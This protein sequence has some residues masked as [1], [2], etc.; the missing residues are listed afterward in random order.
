M[1]AKTSPHYR[2]LRS[3][4]E[5][6]TAANRLA[7]HRCRALSLFVVAL[8]LTALAVSAAANVPVSSPILISQENSTRAIAVDSLSFTAEPFA[9]TSPYA[10]GSDRR[11]RVTLFALN[12]SL[13]PGEDLSL[14]TADAEDGSH[15]HYNLTVEYVGPVPHQEWLSA[16]V[17]R[18]NDSLG[19]VGDV[20]VRVSLRG[21]SSNR[22]RV[23]I[24]H[25]GGGPPDDQGAT[26]TPIKPFFI[27]GQVREDN[28]SAV[29][30]VEVTLNDRTDGT[31]SIATTA[32]DGSYFFSVQ[33]GHSIAVTLSSNVFNFGAQS[34]D[35]L[36]G[37]RVL[38]FS[39]ARRAY[40]IGGHLIGVVNSG[41]VV[42]LSGFR[43]ATTT[44]NNNGDFE[45][46]NLTAGR[47]YTISIPTTPYYTFT[48]QDFF[49]LTGNRVADFPGTLRYY[50]VSG[51]VWLTHDPARHLLIPVSGTRTTTVTTND[52]GEFSISLPAGGNYDFTPSVSYFTFSPPSQGVTNLTSD[53]GGEVFYGVRQ[54]FTI[55]GKL[56]DQESNALPGLTVNL[57]GEEQRT[58]VTDSAGN[59]EFRNLLAGYSYTITPPSTASY[60][61]AA[62]NVNDLPAN[63]TVDFVGLRRLQLSGRVTD[64]SGNALIGITIT[65]AGTESGSTK[66]AADGSYSL[67]ATATGNYTVTPSIPQDYYTFAPASVQF[68][69]LAAASR[70]DF[71][72]APTA[73]PNP[74]QVLEFDGTPKTVDYG[75]FW[76][77]NV[78]LGHFFWEFWAMPGG[79][80]GATYLLSDGY[81]GAHA[82]LFGVGSFNSSEVNRYELLGN[83]FDG[84][85]FDHYFGG[86]VGPAVGEWAHF[87]VGWDGQNIITYYN[88]VPVGKTPFAGPRRTP[89][90]GGGGGRLLIGGSDHSN[91]DGR[92]AEVRGYEDFNPREGAPGSSEASFSPGTVFARGGNLL[93]YF[94]RSSPR[95]IA[96]LSVGYRGSSHAGLLRGTSTG[97]IE[98][99]ESCP[100]PRF[101]TDPSAP[102]FTTGTP[103][104][105]VNVPP[106]ASP[107]G[108]ALI[109]D[110]FSRAN[111]TYTF[112]GLG[113]LGFTESGAAGTKVW[114]SNQAPANPQPFGILNARAVLLA[115]AT[116]VAW[117]PTGSASG[118][119]DVRVSR[120]TGRWGSGIHTGLSFRVVDASNF[121]FAYTADSGSAATS[122]L[123]HVGYYLNGQRVDLTAGVSI[124]SSWTTLR[125]VTIN[126]GALNVYVDDALVYAANSPLLATANGAGLYSDSPGM[127]LVNRWDNFTVL[128]SP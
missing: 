119:L 115:N 7:D 97:L 36:S 64:T 51:R 71:T 6:P 74:S 26:P 86:D 33:P 43:T 34:I 104:A 80:A 13:Q 117:V 93:S 116:A 59:Y 39:G 106:A 9:L 8:S 94:F 105:P 99:C 15:Q 124:P 128:N 69:N 54:L 19:D 32:A 107:P 121:F 42:N 76:P 126:S 92:I 40:A 46:A 89:G 49:N 22:V 88:G 83:I 96:D 67:T 25:V 18:L 108:G 20:L 91:F 12:L 63:E 90:P 101:V 1:F 114:Q 52:D 125:V 3:Y 56:K 127:G 53:R 48:S 118:N 30:G 57:G 66:T 23:G 68:E 11:T 120:Y 58:T 100:P 111:S 110:S 123:V 78:N 70:R 122:K 31:T 102:N 17:L 77:E 2:T 65:L 10:A 82:L 28:S 103:S 85:R 55:R 27:S 47:D 79:N 41:L 37:D 61:F 16:L 72:A 14:V 73:F 109:F 24:G 4:G 5:A 112:G 50:T 60:T 62:Q 29:A 38:N 75:P 98:F 84:A 95:A 45:F 21:S 113:G 87:A 44:T 35:M 81:G